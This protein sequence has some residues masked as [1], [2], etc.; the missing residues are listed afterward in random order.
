MKKYLFISIIISLC[1]FSMS[2]YLIIEVTEWDKKLPFE[3]I[4]TKVESM[5]LSNWEKVWFY[6]NYRD[7]ITDAVT[8]MLGSADAQKRESALA[9]LQQIHTRDSYYLKVKLIQDKK[10]EDKYR[11]AYISNL[12]CP[13]EEWL[14]MKDVMLK[15]IAEDEPIA[16]AAIERVQRWKIDPEFIR[17]LDNHPSKAVQKA[18]HEWRI[19][20]EDFRESTTKDLSSRTFRKKK[21]TALNPD[22]FMKL[23]LDPFWFEKPEDKNAYRHK[24]NNRFWLPLLK[25]SDEKARI[26][27]IEKLIDM[28]PKAF[29]LIAK[30]LL[31]QDTS[32]VRCAVYRQLMKMPDSNMS[33]LI[34]SIMKE[35][36][37][38]CMETIQYEFVKHFY[39]KDAS[40]SYKLTDLEMELLRSSQYQMKKNIALLIRIYCDDETA[41]QR[42]NTQ[43]HSV[44]AGSFYAEIYFDYL[45]KYSPELLVE[46]SF[47]LLKSALSK[48][49]EEPRNRFGGPPGSVYSSLDKQFFLKLLKVTVPHYGMDGVLLAEEIHRDILQGDKYCFT[50]MYA[51][52]SLYPQV[53]KRF[54]NPMPDDIYFYFLLRRYFEGEKCLPDLEK[55]LDYPVIGDEAASAIGRLMGFDDCRS[56][57]VCKKYL[58]LYH[59]GELKYEE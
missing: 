45:Q 52:K 43:F 46:P 54:E 5:N 25:D 58:E 34:S 23:S 3:Q 38:D 50:L 15:L 13:L 44:E 59:K 9:V 29:R 14:N 39:L 10:L 53:I 22:R 12:Q 17:V 2:S 8:S 48:Q 20:N 57:A 55:Y 28:E 24:R 56:V 11:I 19:W 42:V 49:K 26:L 16:L 30:E 32:K 27:A 33:F 37:E 4:V 6:R 36:N 21:K 40:R 35:D 51:D 41:V 7:E 1:C 31:N 47:K 18:L